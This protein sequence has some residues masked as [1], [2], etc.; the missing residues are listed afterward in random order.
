[1]KIEWLGHSSFLITSGE[2]VK[3]ITDPYP[4]GEDLGYPEITESAD[5]VTVSH[6]HFDHNNTSAVLG[7]PEVITRGDN[8]IKGINIR[9]VASWHDAEEGRSR[10]KNNI[11]CLGVSRV[12]VCHLGD[13]GH[14]LSEK[15]VADIGPV[16]ILLIPVGGHFTIDAAGATIVCNQLSPSV[17]IPMHYRNRWCRFPISG[18]DDFLAGKEDVV[19]VEGSEVEF[20]VDSLPAGK[21]IVVLEPRP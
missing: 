2:G 11:F 5:I 19:R 13:L 18:V 4:T 6:D 14:T 3:V 8:N 9:S 17:V 20:S 7:N 21:R 10:G 1:M 15:Q 16:D 12:S